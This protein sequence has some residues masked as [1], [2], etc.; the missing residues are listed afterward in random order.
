MLGIDLEAARRL[1]CGAGGW[2]TLLVLVTSAAVFFS[3]GTGRVSIWFSSSSFPAFSS[4]SDI[5]AS[6]SNE[7]RVPPPITPPP[8]PLLPPA[9]S[10]SS[11][12][13]GFLAPSPSPVG[14][15]PKAPPLRSDGPTST[16]FAPPPHANKDRSAV[17][18][19]PEP[20]SIKN[21]TNATT[22]SPVPPPTASS[23]AEE[24]NASAPVV[25]ISLRETDIQLWQAKREIAVAPLVLN[26]SDLY[27]PLF[28]N[29]SVFKRSYELMERILKVYI[30]KEGEKPLF[31]TPVL[32]G[33]YAS[34]GWF[35]KLMEENEQFVVQDP[36]KAHLFYLPYSSYQLRHHLYVAESHS[37][38]P[39]SSFLRDYV[40]S[41]SAKYPFWNMSRGADHFLV[42]CHDWATYT[43][44]LHL[45]L[46]NNAIKAVCNA[47]ASE[48]IFVRGKD[49][50]LPETYVRNPKKPR[51]SIGGNPASKRPILAF[52]AGQ[53]HG[54]VRP[55]LIHHWK[56]KDD[57]MRI[58]E[59]L[60]KKVARN[61][62]YIQHMKS[63][64][65]CIC[66][67]GYEVNSPRIVEAVSFECVPVVIA[68]NF[69]LPFE[70]VLNWSAF[71][72]VV[73][74]KDIPK[75]KEILLGVS[76][77]QYEVMQMNVKRLKKHFLWNEKPLKYDLFHMILHS[78]WFNRLGQIQQQ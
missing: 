57:D 28:L 67:M 18:S 24:V 68:D 8:P 63:S 46:Q 32:S 78:V 74:E 77:R 70:E 45:E 9:S 31:H 72:M 27:A 5:A 43:T 20:V 23:Y 1:G 22:I 19:P 71:S 36:D 16:T 40:N 41:I 35:M 15:G 69:V 26:D 55:I 25:P 4:Q 47:D 14:Y 54:R 62:S 44:K 2:K 38:Q 17:S 10:P 13:P 66:P 51:A 3:S 30:Y 50:S 42:A 75:L 48:G 52:F 56:E 60:P 76:E 49:V 6:S 34:E 11:A 7:E 65:Y 33:I 21:N 59:V 39:I 64:R 53:M 58:Y 12:P 61:M 29:V 73:A 37:M